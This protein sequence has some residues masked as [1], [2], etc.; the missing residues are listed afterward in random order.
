VSHCSH[1]GFKQGKIKLVIVV[2]EEKRVKIEHYQKFYPQLHTALGVIDF[3]NG[4]VSG[5][6]NRY[7]YISQM[8]DAIN[9]MGKCFRLCI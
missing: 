9:V 2:R 6:C 7:N 4:Y 3:I 5:I 1:K 8:F